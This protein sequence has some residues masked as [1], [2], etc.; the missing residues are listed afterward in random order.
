MVEYKRTNG[1]DAN[2]LTLCEQLSAFLA[3]VNGEKNSFFVQHNNTDAE[4]K[5]ILAW[6][7]GRAVGGGAFR[8]V[9]DGIVEI[10]RMY[11]LPTHRKRGIGHGVLHELNHWAD[12]MGMLETVLETHRDLT[13]AQHMYLG[14]GYQVIPNYGPYIG[15]NESV[16]M[17]LKLR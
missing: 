2:F 12:E 14:F 10:K 11:V 15:V 3:E 17:G 4:M 9:V 8:E 6:E 7:D 16:C 13:A 5:V 1:E